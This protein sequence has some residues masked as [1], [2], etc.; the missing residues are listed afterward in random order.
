MLAIAGQSHIRQPLDGFEE[1]VHSRLGIEI[2]AEVLPK[3]VHFQEGARLR[4]LAIF[5]FEKLAD[6]GKIG[7]IADDRSDVE[8]GERIRQV[9]EGEAMPVLGNRVREAG[10]GILVVQIVILEASVAPTAE[11]VVQVRSC[12]QPAT[13]AIIE[14]RDA[15]EGLI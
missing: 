10:I 11:M 8:V 7:L 2:E 14:M 4:V 5:A 9:R 3:L 13:L 1:T 12:P 6:H 15:I